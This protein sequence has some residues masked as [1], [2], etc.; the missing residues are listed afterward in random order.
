M[1]AIQGAMASRLATS[2]LQGFVQALNGWWW[3]GRTGI[4]ITGSGVSSWTDRVRGGV[5]SQS[6]DAKRPTYSNGILTFNGSQYLIGTPTGISGND[7]MTCVSVAAPATANA[8]VAQVGTT[9]AGRALLALSPS[10]LPDLFVVKVATIN[11]WQESAGTFSL[12]AYAWQFKFSDGTTASKPIY[13]NGVQVTGSRVISSNVSGT[14]T[15]TSVALGARDDGVSP[16]TGTQRAHVL[17]P[18]LLSVAQMQEAMW[19]CQS[20]YGV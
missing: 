1:S 19:L 5:V 14:T 7:A 13:R 20:I 4:V 16:M 2:T 15:G 17:I 6:T 12:A 8:V 11:E 10:S 3:D 18:S 9:G